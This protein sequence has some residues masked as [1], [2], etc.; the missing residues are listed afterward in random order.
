[1]NKHE[2]A[3][4]HRKRLAIQLL[5]HGHN[6]Q[7]VADAIK[8]ARTTITRWRLYH[9]TFQ[10]ELN[11]QRQALWQNQADRLRFMMA[12]ALDTLQSHL[13]SNSER[14]AF[15]S[16][17]NI[18]RLAARITPPAGPTDEY[19]F[20]KQYF[21]CEYKERSQY[22]H[23]MDWPIPKEQLDQLRDYL[24]KKSANQPLILPDSS[25]EAVTLTPSSP[26]Q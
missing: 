20:L 24:L 3:L 1:M 15:R 4:S 23:L 17:V 19:E 14:A 12:S 2:N 22:E 18:V 21:L 8:V 9:P 10:T 7:Q 6:D 13:A 5:L 25:P 11:R 16:A 26:P